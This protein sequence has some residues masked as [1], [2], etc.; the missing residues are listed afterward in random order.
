MYI[1]SSNGGTPKSSILIGCPIQ[2][3]PILGTPI[4]LWKPPWMPPIGN[5]ELDISLSRPPGAVELS[6]S[7]VT[8]SAQTWEDLAQILGV[9]H[10]TGGKSS[11]DFRHVLRILL[12]LCGK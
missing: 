11:G 4:H 1:V 5:N 7:M 3:H 12:R 2:N 6:A 8:H 9:H 10:L